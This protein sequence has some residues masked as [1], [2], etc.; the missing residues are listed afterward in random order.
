MVGNINHKLGSV[1]NSGESIVN[2]VDNS[3][4]WLRLDVP[5]ELTY[6]LKLGM[7][8]ELDV[9]SQPNLNVKGAVSFIAPALDKQTQTLLVKATF[10]NQNG[11]LRN[12]QRVSATI[13]FGSAT[14]LA[15]PEASVLLQAGQTFVFIAA[16][17]SKARQ[18]LGRPL[19]SQAVTGTQVA[20]QIPVELG[21]L[22]NGFY[23]VKRGLSS[24]D[25]LILGNLA[26]ITSG[27]VVSAK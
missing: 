24:S 8:V 12:N 23:P 10:E 2:I 6:R 17:P 20:L 22:E 4:L 1:V 18:L 9:P 13:L 14:Q 16:P 25:R 27:N 3:R 7:P 11:L 19:S 21:T 26:Q 15:I 5:G